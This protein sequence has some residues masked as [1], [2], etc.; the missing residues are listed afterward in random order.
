[1]ANE[2]MISG[3]VRGLYHSEWDGINDCATFEEWKNSCKRQGCFH[4]IEAQAK[5]VL[6]Y[7]INAA[8]T[9]FNI[10]DPAA[11]P[12]TR[13]APSGSLWLFL[14]MDGTPILMTFSMNAL[15]NRGDTEYLAFAYP[16]D[17]MPVPDSEGNF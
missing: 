3:G 11:I 15:V 13:F 16:V 6:K 4:H 8:W 10:D 17:V 2:K 14:E 5:E 7:G 1:M 12:E 9:K